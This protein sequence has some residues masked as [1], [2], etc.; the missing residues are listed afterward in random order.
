M[1]IRDSRWIVSL[2]RLRKRTEHSSAEGKNAKQDI[3]PFKRRTRPPARTSEIAPLLS[4]HDQLTQRHPGRLLKLSDESLGLRGAVTRR[5]AVSHLQHRPSRIVNS[6]HSKPLMRAK[7][8]HRRG[9]VTGAH[10]SVRAIH[11]FTFSTTL[12]TPSRDSA[13]CSRRC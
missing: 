7:D 13:A 11:M 2:E 6:D 4:V 5:N 12:T 9:E 10:H 1:C 3:A 8:L